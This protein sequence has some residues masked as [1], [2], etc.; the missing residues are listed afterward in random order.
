MMSLCCVGLSLTLIEIN[1]ALTST[2]VDRNSF[3]SNS[4]YLHFSSYPEHGKSSICIVFELS[5]ELSQ[6]VAS[7]L[8]K[9]ARTSL[10]LR[11]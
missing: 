3:V 2:Q 5:L 8:L 11:T 10:L 6:P 9:H 4:M 1:F 7:N